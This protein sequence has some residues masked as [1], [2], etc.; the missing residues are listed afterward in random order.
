MSTKPDL[1]AANPDPKTLLLD[2]CRAIVRDAIPAT[3]SG[4][5][6]FVPKYQIDALRV[7]V[8]GAAQSLAARD[9]WVL[10]P[11]EPT[12]EMKQAAL[13]SLRANGIRSDNNELWVAHYCYAAMLAA[14]PTQPQQEARDG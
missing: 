14:A 12:P 13:E 1:G 11:V 3:K 9:G 2:I 8:D 6:C 7:A 5:T 10:V 4:A